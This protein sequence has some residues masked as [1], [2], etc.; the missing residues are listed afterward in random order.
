MV[1]LLLRVP[2]Y[3]GGVSVG[4]TWFGYGSPKHGTHNRSS[5]GGH[6]AEPRRNWSSRRSK[7]LACVNAAP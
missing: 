7:H 4:Q 6:D 1:Q 3:C 5:A 2:I